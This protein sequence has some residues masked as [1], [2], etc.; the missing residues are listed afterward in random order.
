MK[1]KKGG[2]RSLALG[3]LGL[4]NSCNDRK[5]LDSGGRDS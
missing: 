2:I 5:N 1:E 4:S 3:M